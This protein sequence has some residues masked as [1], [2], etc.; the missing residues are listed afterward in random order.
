MHW[1]DVLLP[2]IEEF[3]GSKERTHCSAGLSVSGLQHVGRLRGEVVLTNSLSV[4]LRKKGREV[5]Q[6]LVLYTQDPWKGT[7]GQLSQFPGQEGKDYVNW[8]LKDVPDPHGCHKSWVDHYWED[9]GG[10]VDRFA[11]GVVLERT[12]EVYSKE[13]MQSI[14]L[15]LVSKSNFIRPVI[16]KYRGTMKYPE[17]WIP[18]DAFCTEC[19]TI[20]TAETTEVT[21]NGEI[22]YS[23]G[24]GH[25]GVSRIE[26]G[27]LNWRL[28]WPALWKLLEVDIEVFGKDHATPGGSR[29]SCKEIARKIL[30]IEPPCGIA[31]EWVGQHSHGKDLGDM[32]SSRFLGFTPKQWLEIGEPEVLRY[33]YLYNSTSRRIVLDL[34]YVDSY[35][36]RFDEA[37]ALHFEGSHDDRARAYV[38]SLMEDVAEKRP[39]RLPY[40]HATLLAQVAPAEDPVGWSVNRLKDTGFLRIELSEEE[41]E[42]VAGRLRMARNWVHRYAPEDLKVQV[43]EDVGDV[44]SRLGSDDRTALGRFRESLC[45]IQWTEEELKKV[46]TSLTKSGELPVSTRRFFRSLYLA[47]LGRERG[48]RAAPFLSVLDKNFVL[49]R[50]EE[51]AD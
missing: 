45:D 46:M 27:K 36:D 35:H 7:E 14:V 32:S 8:R 10:Y 13:R 48:P 26:D 3:L 25:D 19:N 11:E 50:L 42:Q 44:T 22:H 47:F 21:E 9:F 28:E 24:K 51:L 5:T 41:R 20:G 40:R 30:D 49:K 17:G 12:G 43:L 16:N 33:I 4:E 37:E 38:L 6:N 29:D 18:F 31:Y 34:S 39:F 1:V 23:C 15:N 2:Q